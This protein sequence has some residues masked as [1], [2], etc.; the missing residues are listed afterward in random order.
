[1]IDMKEQN[2]EHYSTLEAGLPLGAAPQ[3]TAEMKSD[4]AVNLQVNGQ[5]QSH[6]QGQWIAIRYLEAP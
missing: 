5:W 1:M 2:K 4:I 3:R 6:Q